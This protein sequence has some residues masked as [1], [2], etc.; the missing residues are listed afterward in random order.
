MWK[1]HLTESGL[2][3]QGLEEG[4]FLVRKGC[5]L[6][7]SLMSVNEFSRRKASA[8]WSL[9]VELTFSKSGLAQMGVPQM[10]LNWGIRSELQGTWYP[11]VISLDVRGSRK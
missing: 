5:S 1:M 6:S 3:A 2:V 4:P 8:R 9:L 11:L 10:F 7:K